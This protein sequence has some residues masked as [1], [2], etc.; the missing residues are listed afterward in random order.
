MMNGESR[1]VLLSEDDFRKKVTC[2][3]F[4]S[5]IMVVLIHAYWV[6]P[7]SSMVYSPEMPVMVKVA[8]FL[9]WI[10]HN[11]AVQFFFILSGYLLFKNLNA[12]NIKRKL[13]SRAFSL[14]IP[15]VLWNIFYIIFWLI[16]SGLGW[17]DTVVDLNVLSLLKAIVL[18]RYFSTYWFMGNLILYVALTPFIY[19]ASK[20]KIVLIVVD[21]LILIDQFL[22]E[23]GGINVQIG[24]QGAFG[25]DWFLYFLIGVNIAVFSPDLFKVCIK[26]KHIALMSIGGGIAC[27]LLTALLR[28]IWILRL[29]I[30]TI[31]ILFAVVVVCSSI[32]WSGVKVRPWMRKSFV[33]YSWH[34][35]ICSFV[36]KVIYRVFP[37]NRLVEIFDY[38]SYVVIG[39][40]VI[41]ILDELGKKF[42]PQIRHLFLGGRDA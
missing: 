15:Y 39:L 41:L 40:A 26:A 31:S 23:Y 25:T 3:S 33:I 35:M 8:Y 28:Q 4:V 42:I 18:H 11:Y 34:G 24:E 2:M 36:S 6:F 29:L 1:F 12:T 16:A 20:K 14:V 30:R 32:N 13:K 9:T 7:E 38:F 37:S 22:L 27:I 5:A 10:G 17:S 21:L 19:L